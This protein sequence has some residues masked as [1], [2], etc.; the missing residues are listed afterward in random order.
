MLAFLLEFVV[1]PA[2]AQSFAFT[3]QGHLTDGGAQ[4]NGA[5]DLQFGLYTTNADGS[6][7]GGLITNSGVAVTSG[8]FMATLDFGDVFN[9]SAMWLE[10]GVRSHGSTGPFVILFPRQN[11]SPAP[12][13]LYSLNAGARFTGIY[14]LDGSRAD[15]PA[16]DKHGEAGFDGVPID[17]WSHVQQRDQQWAIFGQRRL[18]PGGEQQRGSGELQSFRGRR[19]ELVSSARGQ[20]SG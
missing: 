20:G 9:G 11:L 17:Q 6:P 15:E 8:L 12:F 14:S 5:Y 3:Y 13:A 1:C 10:I 7:V 19:A 16:G 18:D 4:A 2:Y